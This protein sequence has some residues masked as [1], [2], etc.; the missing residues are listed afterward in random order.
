M[1]RINPNVYDI[2]TAADG[3]NIRDHVNTI[4]TAID[5]IDA[6][7]TFHAVT[8][9][10][11]GVTVQDEGTSLATVATT[12][13]F[14]GAGVTASNSGTASTKIIN[15]PGGTSG[16]AANIYNV[17]DYGAIGNNSTDDRTAIQSLIDT[18]ES[19]LGGTIFF[20]QGT[21]AVSSPG[22]TI[23]RYNINMVGTGFDSC[24]L[25][26]TGTSG[27][28]I[29]LGS[30]DGNMGNYS[31]VG[32]AQNCMFENLRFEGSYDAGSNTRTGTPHG[33]V[34]YE[35][36]GIIMRNCYF[37]KLYR[38]FW[39]IASD[40]NSF[41][42]VL[43]VRCE[44]GMQFEDRSDQLVISNLYAIACYNALIINNV[45]NARIERAAFVDQMD[46]DVILG[47]GL[48]APQDPLNA[49]NTYTTGVQLRG[50]SAI[51]LEDC[52]FETWRSSNTGGTALER[53]QPTK[54]GYV[55]VGVT[56]TS[57]STPVN[58]V[59]ILNSTYAATRDAPAPAECIVRVGYAE[60]VKVDG[61]TYVYNETVPLV[62]T[63]QSGYT[64]S[65]GSIFYSGDVQVNNAYAR[66]AY[67]DWTLPLLAGDR[68][69]PLSHRTDLGFRRSIIPNPTFAKSLYGWTLETMTAT[70]YTPGSDNTISGNPFTMTPTAQYGGLY[71]A[72]RRL[73][74]TT[75]Y[76]VI[77]R[78]KT[79]NATAT[80]SNKWQ[81]G[82]N[83]GYTIPDNRF[84]RLLDPSQTWRE[85]RFTI[86]NFGTTLTTPKLGIRNLSPTL[87]E[88]LTIDYVDV[89][90]MTPV[91]PGIQRG[92]R[93]EF[94]GTAAPAAGTWEVGDVIH[95]TAPAASGYMGFT[96]TTAGTPGTWKGF[97]LIQA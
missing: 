18:L 34:D 37:W 62:L 19:G 73:R 32:Y 59:R 31:S 14:T 2:A 75:A 4:V 94:F 76:E 97:G 6:N 21:Y 41:S 23:N 57:A 13:N 3:Q 69:S 92:Q 35:S 64:D 39:G 61:I 65:G 93:A 11:S 15:I 42:D 87:T 12:F 51:T 30:Y 71:H 91:D 46:V 25:R 78:Y 9:G 22:L 82:F 86:A 49:A 89:Q 7:G 20:P 33:I 47:Y 60:D 26:Y 95:N 85:V 53:G 77:L 8:G 84:M 45:D 58:T 54:P 29:R 90:E 70:A 17:K 79:S 80:G 27:A 81:I 24:G 55:T 43:L 74:P 10:G 50:A 66:H 68:I 83:D 28:L 96:C 52:W 63:T 40:L 88:T 16:T 1:A 38:G 48:A 5:D 44:I 56:N 36:G 67:N 72:L